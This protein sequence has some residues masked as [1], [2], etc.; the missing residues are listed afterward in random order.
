MID[1]PTA[2][3]LLSDSGL[4]APL[5]LDRERSRMEADVVRQALAACGGNKSEAARLLGISRGTLYNKLRADDER[6]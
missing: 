2:R 1:A 4:Q 5:D 6:D 3:R